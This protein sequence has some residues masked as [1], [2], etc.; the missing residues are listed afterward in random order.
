[1]VCLES[2]FATGHIAWLAEGWVGGSPKGLTIS[3]PP[4]PK[5]PQVLE[6]ASLSLPPQPLSPASVA[7]PVLSPT[8]PIIPSSQSDQLVFTPLRKGC[9]SAVERML[10]VQQVPGSIPC[11]S[12]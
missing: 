6:A 12:I 7:K 10:A 9:N 5:P 11:M 2:G 8:H 3:A 1:M 4:N